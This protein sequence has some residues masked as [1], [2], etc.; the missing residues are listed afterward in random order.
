MGFEAEIITKFPF[1]ILVKP[2]NPQAV[3]RS[4][5]SR[6]DRKIWLPDIAAI[7]YIKEVNYYHQQHIKE[8]K[9][10]DD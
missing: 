8:N 5:S 1:L 7:F 6:S 2:T 9:Y 10:N 4:C 3:Q